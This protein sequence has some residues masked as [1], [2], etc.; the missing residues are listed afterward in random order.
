MRFQ[1]GIAYVIK[2]QLDQIRNGQLEVN[3]TFNLGDIGKSVPDS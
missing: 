2:C 1:V 3:I